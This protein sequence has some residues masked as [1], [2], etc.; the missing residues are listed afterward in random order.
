[1]LS[2]GKPNGIDAGMSRVRKI[3]VQVPESLLEQAQKSSG[4][5]ITE[6]V[7]R[8]L[9][10]VAAGDTYRKLRELRGEVS[11]SIDIETLREDRL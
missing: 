4:Q 2:H 8:G 7:R 1:M 5:G 3:T 6:T 10:L 11:L 9:Q